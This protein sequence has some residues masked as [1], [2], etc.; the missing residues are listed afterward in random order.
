MPF[1]DPPVVVAFDEG[2]DDGSGLIEGL[3][4]VELSRFG[5]RVRT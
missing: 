1:E 2:A 3:E 5:G 4:V